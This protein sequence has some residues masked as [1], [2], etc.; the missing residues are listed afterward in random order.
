MEY[1]YGFNMNFKPATDTPPFPFSLFLSDR[2]GAWRGG[3]EQY[4]ISTSRYELLIHLALRSLV[5]VF[6]CNKWHCVQHT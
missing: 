2:G 3:G 5:S 1:E 6:T 4:H